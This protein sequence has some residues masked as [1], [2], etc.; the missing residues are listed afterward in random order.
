MLKYR[1]ID[2]RESDPAPIRWLPYIL[3]LAITAVL[4]IPL[5]KNIGYWGIRDWDLFTTLHAAAVRSIVEFGQ[6]PFWN[7]Y[8]GGGNILF[9]HP[10]VPVLNP[11]FGLLLIFGPLIG[12]KIQVVIVYFIGLTGFYKLSRQEGIGFWGALMAAIVFMLSSYLTLHFAVGHIPFHSFAVFP[13]LLFFYR[14]SLTHPLHILS[15]GA[16]VGFI[17]LGSGAAV[18]LL[19]SLFFLFLFS[20]FDCAQGRGL[21]PPLYAILAG[22]CGILFG[23][24]KFFPMFDYLNRHPWIPDGTVQITSWSALPKMFFSF[25]Q[26]PFAQHATE[27]WGWHEYGAFIGPM[28][29]FLALVAVVTRFRQVWPYVVLICFSLVLVLGSFWPP[30]SPWDLLHKL[31]GFESIRVPSRFALLALICVALLAG[32]GVDALQS[33]FAYRRMTLGILLCGTV[34]VTHLIVCLP[35]LNKAFVRPPAKLRINADFKQI[36]GDPNQMYSA[37]LA[38]RGT[39]RAAWLSAYRPGRGILGQDNRA[40]EWY[41]ENKAV[42]VIGREFSPNRL[43]F[44]LQTVTGGTLTISQGFDQGWRRTDGGEIKPVSDLVSFFVHPTDQ[45]IMLEYFPDYFIAGAVVTKLSI[46][47]AIFGPVIYR[48][49]RSS[50]IPRR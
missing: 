12:L 6:F 29:A 5:L 11:L 20:L 24:I 28:A 45:R 44:D 3:F 25:Q 2:G 9:A 37:F 42:T 4:A 31:P 1:K 49:R 35:I 10:E 26:S 14:K 17:I 15:A 33:L 46:L 32:R 43:A 27:V 18:P 34:L 39:L 19:F 41:S 13:W 48:R 21:R 8:I 7:P 38:N 47:S 16:V 30:F 22:I 23:A 50:K 36:E 40:S